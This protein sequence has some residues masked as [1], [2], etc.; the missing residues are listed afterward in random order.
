MHETLLLCLS[1]LLLVM[2]L[3]MLAQRLRVSYPIFL[4][5]GGLLISFIPGV[6]VIKVDHEL[7]FLI[8]LPPLLY[9]AAWFTSWKAFWKWRRVIS[10]NAFLLVMLTSCVVAIVAQAFLPG[11]TLALGFLLGGIVSPPDAVAATSV[12]KGLKVPK[13]VVTILEGESL[14]NDASSLIIFRFALAAV[15]SGT[16]I[17]QKAATDFVLVTGVGIIVGLVIAHIF[18]VIHRWLPTTPSIDTALTVIAPYLMYLVAE[19][20][21]FSGVMAVVSGGLFLSYRNHEIFS[22][23]TRMQSYS[24]WATLGFVLNGTV[25]ILI[26]LELPVIV[27]ELGEYSKWEAIGYGVLITGILIVTRM[28]VA[29]GTSLFTRFM[30]RFIWVNDANPGWK[31]PLVIGWAGMRGVVSLASALSIPPLL[32]NGQPFPQRNLILFI[33]FVVI[34]LTLVVQGLTLPAIINFVNLKEQDMA[35]EEEQEAEIRVRLVKVAIEALESQYADEMASNEWVKNL[36]R[37]MV[38]DHGHAEGY[39]AAVTCIPEQ[40][41]AVSRYREIHADLLKIQRR[42][43]YKMRKRTE[44]DDEVIRKQEAQ[45]DLDEASLSMLH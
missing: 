24:L 19:E 11:F 12:T 4:V 23:Q 3:V 6:P 26:G 37:R 1:L 45:M 42:E 8:F 28:A 18:Y 17:W 14:V 35:P 30:S 13:R 39:L 41:E 25:F 20:F 31:Y 40:K 34:L 44:L 2:V 32:D 9:E 5:L 29:M 7:I 15:L 21:H 27:D 36:R 22:Y 16:F 43:L 33:T 10:T 38:A